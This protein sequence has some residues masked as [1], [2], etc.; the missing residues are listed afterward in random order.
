VRRRPQLAAIAVA[1]AAPG[2]QH[3]AMASRAARV[4]VALAVVAVAVAWPRRLAGR[5]GRAA[6]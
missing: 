4:L 2:R 5:G 1:A 6:S 3:D